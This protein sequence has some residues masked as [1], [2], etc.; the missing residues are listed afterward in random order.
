MRDKRKHDYEDVR[1][2]RDIK[3]MLFSSARLYGDHPAMW[4]KDKASSPYRPITYR[5]LLRD[6]QGLGT[7]LASL[8]LT[9]KKIG[10]IGDN[11]YEWALTYLAVVCGIGVIVPLDKELGKEELAYLT[12]QSGIEAVIYAP[13]FE[14]MFQEMREAGN[15]NLRILVS[16]KRLHELVKTGSQKLEA[17]DKTFMNAQIDRE[18]LSILLY[19]SGTTGM[20]KGVMLC[21]R[22]I[23]EN[24]MTMVTLVNIRPEDKFFSVLPVHHTYEGTC[25]FLVPLYRGASIAYCEGLK[26]IVKNL[27]EAKPT[28]FLGVPLIFESIYKKIWS[29][30]QKSGLDKKLRTLLEWNKK[31]QKLGINLAPLFFKKVTDIFGGRMRLMICGGAYINPTI[32]E[33]LQGFGILALQGYGLTECS[34]IL[35]INPDF[36]PVASAAGRTPAGVEARITDADENGIGEIIV[37]GQNVMMGYYENPEATAQVLKDGWFYTG[38]LGRIDAGGYIYIT[39]R[40]KNVIITKNGKNV[41]PEEL[42]SYLQGIALVEECLVSAQQGEEADDLIITAEIITNAE[43]VQKT[44]GESYTQEEEQALVWSK[45][46]EL[47]EKMPF[48]KKI[49]KIKIRKEAFDKTTSKKIKRV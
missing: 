26:Y 36:A 47:N 18:A 21:Q 25:G 19:T 30:A 12:Q 32:L 1:P 14:S 40:K 20:A 29:Q 16:T 27:S 17:G 35:A 7:E 48:Y 24:L 22:N 4:V 39:G 10:V 49:K 8:G 42:E 41:F 34:P 44:L 43:E 33:D 45:V 46:D 2:I 28:V 23:A 11:G 31:T 3:D 37:R 9:G 38:D 6:V 5:T 15:T 13:K